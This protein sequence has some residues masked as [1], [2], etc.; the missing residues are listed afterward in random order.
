M[1]TGIVKWFNNRK[2]YGFITQPD[3][4]QDIFVH[5]TAIVVEDEGFRS[6]NEGDEV[7]FNIE[8]GQKGPEARNVVITKAAPRPF[9]R[10]KNRNNFGG[11][12]NR[13]W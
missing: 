5:Y 8:E 6:L 12:Y 2:G 7:E 13:R 1:P 11:G 10:S 3:S 4:D 9:R